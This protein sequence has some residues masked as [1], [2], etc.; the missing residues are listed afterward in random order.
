MPDFSVI[1]CISQPDVFET[2]LLDSVYQAKGNFDVEII[3]IFNHENRYSASNAFNIGIDTSRSDVCIFAHQDVRLLPGW[4]EQLYQYVNQMPREWAVL[5]SAGINL[6]Y[7]RADIGKWGGSLNVDT[8]AV[9]RVWNNDDNLEREADWCGIKDL[10]TVHCV[11]E[12][13]M[14]LN[15][16]SGLR[17]DAMFQFHFYTVDLCLQARSAAYLVYGADLPIV[18]YGQYS[19]SLTQD[20][21]YWPQL[22]YLHYKWRMRYPELL[23]THMHWSKGELTSYIPFAMISDDDIQVKIKSAGVEKVKLS[24]DDQHGILDIKG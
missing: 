15:K 13:L 9:G 21:N 6:M 7:N 23:G 11:D 4:F 18:H 1:S 5:G 3:P 22:R 17:F 19:Q 2:C 8:V 14:V 16:K 10:T 20:S 24:L 12:C